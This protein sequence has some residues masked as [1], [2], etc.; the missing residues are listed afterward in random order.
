YLPQGNKPGKWLPRIKNFKLY[1]NG[2]H[3]TLE[4]HKWYGNRV[5][6]CE[7]CEKGSK[8]YES[9]IAVETFRFLKEITIDSCIDPRI[10]VR[11]ANLEWANLAGLD[12]SEVNLVG[13]NLLCANL[14]RTDLRGA[15]LERANLKFADLRGAN[16]TGAILYR[17]DLSGANLSGTILWHADLGESNLRDTILQRADL[18]GAVL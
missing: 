6:L 2:Y 7:Y 1:E 9:N 4:P 13:A 5:F 3:L 15:N 11:I 8:K 17:A 16:L 18:R 12:L 10:Y 14:A